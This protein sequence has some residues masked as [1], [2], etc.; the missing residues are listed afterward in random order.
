MN[1]FTIALTPA[2]TKLLIDNRTEVE[3]LQASINE[4]N[5]NV[6]NVLT[7]ICLNG[8]VDPAIQ[9]IKLTDD[10][11]SLEIVE[12]SELESPENQKTEPTGTK[13]RKMK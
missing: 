4:R 8:G 10:C 5:M 6:S 7:G 3:K 13:V 11:T 9:R 12:F 2:I 1:N